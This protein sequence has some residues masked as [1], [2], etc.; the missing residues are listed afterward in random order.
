MFIPEARSASTAFRLLVPVTLGVFNNNILSQET[1]YLFPHDHVFCFGA[2]KQMVT[3]SATSIPFN[4]PVVN[5]K[6]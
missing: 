5:A 2:R 6:E 4:S 1:F 3:R